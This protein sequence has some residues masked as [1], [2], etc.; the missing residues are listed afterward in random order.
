MKIVHLTLMSAYLDGWGYQE[1]YLVAENIKAGHSVTVISSADNYGIDKS[2]FEE[3]ETV[4]V[5]GAKLIR[6]KYK[7]NFSKT[8]NRKIRIYKGIEKLLENENPDILFCHGLQTA[9]LF[10]ISRYLK[11]HPNCNGYADNHSDKYN[12]GNNIW[13]IYVLHKGIYRTIIQLTKKRFKKIYYTAMETGEFLR[14]NYG[15]QDSRDHLEFL[16]L[17][18]YIPSEEKYRTERTKFRR[19]NRVENDEILLLHTGKFNKSKRTEEFLRVF[20]EYKNEKVKLFLAGSFTEEIK[21]SCIHLI[22]KDERITFLG[23]VSSKE[24][25][26]VMCGCD[27]LVQPQSHSVVYQQAIC[28]SMAVILHDDQNDRFLVSDNNGWLINDVSEIPSIMDEACKYGDKLLEMRK[29]AKKFAQQKLDY[30][31]LAN[32]YIEE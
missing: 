21:N 22:E 16:S 25:S 15:L 11:K 27:I 32:K 6:V 9:E 13:S 17:G 20:Y 5:E 10:T 30:K 14:E 2:E 26:N 24:L 18:G 23:W 31:V 12:S 19:A 29:R 7:Y 28:N 8:F 3:G 1:N 4:S